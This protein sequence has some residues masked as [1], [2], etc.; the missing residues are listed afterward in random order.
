MAYIL[1]TECH[2]ILLMTLKLT[3]SLLP[4]SSNTF[5]SA[6][7]GQPITNLHV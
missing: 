7:V 5:L 6:S 1:L 4:L 2:V 3:S